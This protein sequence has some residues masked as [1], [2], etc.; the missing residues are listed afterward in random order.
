MEIRLGIDNAVVRP[1]RTSDAP[2]LA[3]HANNRGVWLQ[4]RDRFPH[5]YSL[6]DAR[7]FLQQA[8]GQEPQ[9][10]FAIAVAGEA[11]GGIELVLGEDVERLS[12]EIGYWLGEAYWNRGIATAAVRAMTERG[13][14]QLGLVR[15]FAAVYARN[16]ASCR[17]LEKCGYE[18]EGVLRCSAIK[19]GELLDRRLYA[20]LRSDHA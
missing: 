4:V 18:L 9:T 10:C 2:S 13:F 16:A 5:P 8:L 12:A 6:Q 11:A 1:W 17:V 20:R 19:D 14:Q 3:R 15:L 7:Q